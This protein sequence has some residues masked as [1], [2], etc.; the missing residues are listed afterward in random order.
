MRRESV[1]E[2]V[3]DRAF[4]TSLLTPNVFQELYNQQRRAL[5]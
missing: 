4:P 3:D 2:V 5:P 1:E